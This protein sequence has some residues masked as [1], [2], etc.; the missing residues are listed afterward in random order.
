MKKG[1]WCCSHTTTHHGDDNCKAQC[2]QA[3]TT[4]IIDGCF[5][6]SV[7]ALTRC[8]ISTSGHTAGFERYTGWHATALNYLH[9]SNPWPNDVGIISL[10]RYA[11]R[12]D[13]SKPSNSNETIWSPVK[14]NGD[15]VAVPRPNASSAD[16]P[17]HG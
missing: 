12:G 9:D 14:V 11:V 15:V 16:R 8:S 2:W 7:A 3:N 5:G 4:E 1:P 10:T 13:Q 17:L 6:N